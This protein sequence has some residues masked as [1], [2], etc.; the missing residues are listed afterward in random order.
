MMFKQ[1]EDRKPGEAYLLIAAGSGPSSVELPD[2]TITSA[3]QV[4]KE[5]GYC[6]LLAWQNE[7]KELLEWVKELRED[8]EL[9]KQIKLVVDSSAYSAWTRH[10]QI[11]IDEYIAFI[12]NISDVVYWFAEL[13]KIPGEFG[14]EKTKQQI[15]E[16]PEIS[17]NNFLYMVERVNC[18]KKILPVFHMY[19]DYK[20][21]KKMLS[22]QFEDG[23]FIEYIGISPSNDASV[24][25][26]A[27]WY[28]ETWRI[29]YEECDR[30]GRSIP[31]SHNFGMTTISLMEQYPSM[32][33]DSTSWIRGASFG[34]IMLVVNGKIKTVYVSNRN[35]ES[36][37]HI[38]NQSP[39]VKEAVEKMCK[40]V[41][42]GITLQHLIDDEKGGLRPIFNLY[43]LHK[44]MSDFEYLG[45]TSFKQD[46][47]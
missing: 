41:G 21:L 3:R 46:L 40:E 16:A 24:T 17:W 29:I 33:S 11:D 42:H 26:K 38:N 43:S 12:N 7:K 22:Y 6:Q 19:E 2:G 10:I 47:W 37:D 34:N 39:A 15:E 30:L 31:K 14:K 28:E 25:D 27:K 13:D 1:F 9:R 20:W 36:P 5:L 18:P 45:D 4:K 32:S 23:G 8:P 44:W 35:P